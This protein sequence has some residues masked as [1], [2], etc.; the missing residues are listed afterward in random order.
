MLY[1]HQPV[2]QVLLLL[3]VHLFRFYLETL[4]QNK[5]KTYIHIKKKSC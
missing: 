3:V 1:S 5:K 4:V 2:D